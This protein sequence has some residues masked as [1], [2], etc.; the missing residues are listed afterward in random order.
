M[1]ESQT[2]FAS[3]YP[4][5]GFDIE[6][7]KVRPSPVIHIIHFTHPGSSG[8]QRSVDT[9]GSPNPPKA[10]RSPNSFGANNGDTIRSN[11]NALANYAMGLSLARLSLNSTTSPPTDP[12]VHCILPHASLSAPTPVETRGLSQLSPNPGI[13][14]AQ[15]TQTPI[16]PI[17]NSPYFDFCYN[18][19]DGH[20][21][22]EHFEN[23]G[24]ISIQQSGGQ[25]PGKNTF[26]SSPSYHHLMI[27]SLIKPGTV[28]TG[29]HPGC[30]WCHQRCYQPYHLRLK[31]PRYR[32]H[33]WSSQPRPLR[34]PRIKLSLLREVLCLP[35][36][37]G[38]LHRHSILY[39][40]SH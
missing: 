3:Q 20:P 14:S 15:R 17:A 36:L 34:S 1:D 4:S 19:L 7:A 22:S 9:A 21:R 30:S 25:L 35:V 18:L 24:R 23:D 8:S 40:C 29:F 37:L 31:P 39:Q 33:R 10:R 32:L 26:P 16:R 2:A 12:S 13:T 28:F 6:R 27:D 38:R 11:R 5:S